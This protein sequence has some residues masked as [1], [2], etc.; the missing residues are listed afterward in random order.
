MPNIPNRS[1]YGQTARRDEILDTALDV[2]APYGYLGT[3]TDMLARES[4]ISKQTLYKYFGDKDG[5]FAALVQRACERV[6]DPFAPRV[7]EMQTVDTAER[8]VR[9]L[10]DQ[11]VGAIM[12]PEI[13]KLRRLVIAE[14]PRFPHLAEEY[15]QSG[16]GRMLTSL[17]ECFSVLDQRGLLR[18]PD[19]EFAA[20]HF[21]GMM[22]W[23]PG[24]RAMFLVDQPPPDESEVTA[25]VSAGVDAFL[26]AYAR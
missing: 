9:I 24:N 16:F 20:Q 8:A 25:I 3:T 12:N 17:A 13:Q 15:W 18:A 1:T 23:I 22:L 26:R 19:L 4:A 14:A 2:F 7:D 5:V 10:A 11:F 6:V 21:A